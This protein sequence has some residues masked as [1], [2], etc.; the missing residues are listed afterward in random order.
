MEKKTMTRKDWITR[1]NRGNDKKQR[2]DT[3]VRPYTLLN[4]R[5]KSVNPL[6]RLFDVLTNPLILTCDIT[7]NAVQ[8]ACY[9]FIRIFIHNY[10]MVMGEIIMGCPQR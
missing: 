10:L 5:T 3:W 1:M 8:F 7:N 6:E 4:P 2:A 9:R